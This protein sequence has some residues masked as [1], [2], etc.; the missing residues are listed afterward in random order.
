MHLICLVEQ[1]TSRAVSRIYAQLKIR[2]EWVSSL[3]LAWEAKTELWV[4]S[5]C[6]TAFSIQAQFLR[7]IRKQRYSPS[8]DLVPRLGSAL[9][10]LLSDSNSH[11]PGMQIHLLPSYFSSRCNSVEFNSN[12]L[13]P[14]THSKAA[15]ADHSLLTSASCPWGKAEPRQLQ[16]RHFSVCLCSLPFTLFAWAAWDNNSSNTGI[17]GSQSP[18]WESYFNLSISVLAGSFPILQSI[19]LPL[20]PRTRGCGPTLNWFAHIRGR[21]CCGLNYLVHWKFR[22]HPVTSCQLFAIRPGSPIVQLESGQL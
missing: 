10:K 7:G 18:W 5:K 17:S 16:V 9:R 19:I 15:A 14:L 20:V 12:P 8:L 3:E 6:W 11:F 21:G 4:A 2:W 13:S 1:G 22:P